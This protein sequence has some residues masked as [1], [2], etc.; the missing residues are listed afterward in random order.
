MKRSDIKQPPCYFD[1]YINQVEDS[2]LLDAFE[3]S[4]SELEALD[5]KTFCELGDAVY[6]EGK[7]TIKDI[8]QHL[9]DVEYILA[10]R[11]LRI[12]RNDKTSLS[13][14]DEDLLAKNVDTS[15][16]DLA[17]LVFEFSVG[18]SLNLQRRER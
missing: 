17:S 8:F 11:A 3:R 5:L 13:G 2:E 9:I 16:R 1:R 15:Q 14:F 6:A 12:A 10:Y 4:R 7:W 18:E